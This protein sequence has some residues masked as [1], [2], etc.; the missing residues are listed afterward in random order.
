MILR[1]P[2]M[3]RAPLPQLERRRR[4]TG[5]WQPRVDAHLNPQ[6]QTPPA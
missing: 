2:L 4:A 1:V 5:E 6:R 3:V